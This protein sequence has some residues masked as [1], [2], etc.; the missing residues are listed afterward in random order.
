MV[1]VARRNLLAEKARLV[2]SVAGV[3]F[4]VL[5]IL[6]VL[7]LYRGWSGVGR[8]ITKLPGDVWVVQTG[9]SDPFH[10]TSFLPADKQAALRAVPG[11]QTVMP[12]YARQMAFSHGGAD[13]NVFF[14]ALDAPPGLPLPPETRERYFPPAGEV[15][16]DSVFSRKTGIRQGDTVD[17]IGHALKVAHINDGGNAVITQFAFL[18]AA[19]AQAIFGVPGSVNFFLL[20]TQPGAGQL[21][22]AAAASAVVPG[23]EART[24]EQFGSAISREVDSG[25]LPVVSVLVAIGFIVGGAVI[26]LTTYT[27]TIEKSRDF[28]VLKALGASSAFLYRI[29]ITQSLIV[30][31]LGSLAGIVASALAASMIKRWI[32]EFITDLRWTDVSI[33]FGVALVMAIL[34]SY[35]PVRRINGIDPAMV[36]R[37]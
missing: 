15:N 26:G 37:A 10:S 11:V 18:N 21:A 27:A 12:V 19:D 36:F 30:G 6:L 20:T 8:L 13:L 5:L 4:A 22:I 32:P 14:M 7:S 17:I 34:A 3:A 33:V 25:F 16:I 29:V 24:S 28:G 23:S 9:T 1:P 35:L 31:I 2:M